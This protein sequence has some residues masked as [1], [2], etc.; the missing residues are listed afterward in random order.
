MTRSCSGWHPPTPGRPP[1]TSRQRSSSHTRLP[2]RQT[3]PYS[4]RHA[5]L[6]LPNLASPSMQRA[7]HPVY[8]RKVMKP[9]QSCW[10]LPR[11]RDA[12]HSIQHCLNCLAHWVLCAV[13][14]LCWASRASLSR[15]GR[16]AR[17][18]GRWSSPPARPPRA[19]PR[20]GWGFR[21]ASPR[22]ARAPN[23]LLRPSCAAGWRACRRSSLPAR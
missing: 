20:R 13:C 7:R 17:A 22:G 5:T 16:A 11:G 15:P 1:A 21:G 3:T 23:S 4:L 8:P 12:W 9:C 19:G 14:P 10:P 18:P 6:S 2:A